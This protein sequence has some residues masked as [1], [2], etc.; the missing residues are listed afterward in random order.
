MADYK[1][2]FY[3]GS[4]YGLGTEANPEELLNSPINH[5][6]YA[7][8]FSVG[9]DP[10]TNNQL[11]AVSEKFNTGIKAVEVQMLTPEVAESIPNQ[12]LT[13]LNRLRK[14]TGTE[15]TVHGPLVEPTGVIQNHWDE[16]QRIQAERQILDT[17]KR[18]QK[19]DPQ[20]NVIVTLHA[21]NGLP[22]PETW[23]V[24]ANGKKRLENISVIDERTGALGRLPKPKVDWFEG[25]KEPDPKAE[26]DRFNKENWSRSLSN[27]SIG[28]TRTSDMF[29]ERFSGNL[30]WLKEK[31]IENMSDFIKLPRS[32]EGKRWLASLG[33]EEKNQAQEIL[34]KLSYITAFTTDSYTQLKEMFNKAYESSKD[35]KEDRK[36]LDSY[37]NEVKPI[38]DAYKNDSTKVLE[39]SEVVSKGLQVLESLKA[40]PQEYKEIKDFAIE[41]SAKTFG[42]VAFDAYKDAKSRNEAAPVI[43]I[44]NPPAGMGISRAE[45]IKEVV[46]KARKNF[47]ERAI[48]SGM[49]ESK[50]KEEAEKLIGATWDVGHIN[51]IRKYGF[52]EKELREEA[53][54][55]APY[56]K[57]IHLSDNFGMEHT[58]LP[59]GMG[60]V[61][62]K[63]HIQE[64]SK[65]YEEKFAKIKKVIEAGNWYQN[66][67]TTPFSETLAAFGSP[68]YG[69]KMAPY[70]NQ[71]WQTQGGYFAGYGFNP[72]VHHSIYG[73]GF[74]NL[75]VELGGQMAGRSRMS[76]APIE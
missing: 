70:W 35:N 5:A 23:V 74:S 25:Q 58:E 9:T 73:S 54:T 66:F 68:I 56:L 69:M 71:S 18:A 38:V 3:G 11:K 41:K 64:L 6:T 51:M 40:V 75:P 45:E 53:K 59:M 61:P 24:D 39:L 26:L 49:S 19:V 1:L 52:G 30:A 57:H 20:G 76:G 17:V 32:E 72:E 48:S 50:A 8:T 60:N 28:A 22:E 7:S 29:D 36:K 47:V 55:I 13:E 27:I 63:A 21:S 15:L 42:N 62:M 67:Q 37:M 34:G 43:S 14:L 2:N 31:G 12:H 10:R 44:E 16:Q 33:K 4:T 46:E 65:G